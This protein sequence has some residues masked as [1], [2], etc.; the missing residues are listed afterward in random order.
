MKA[1]EEKGVIEPTV[2]PNWRFIPEEIAEPA[3][4]ADSLILFSGS[5]AHQ[6]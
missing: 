1:I 3:L 4:R 2:T 5:T 6:K